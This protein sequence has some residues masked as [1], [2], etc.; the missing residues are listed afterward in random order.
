MGG[1]EA[2]AGAA[3][4]GGWRRE[5]GAGAL[6]AVACL[7]LSLVSWVRLLRPGFTHLLP[8][9]G[10][11]DDG[12]GVW[13]LEW[14]PFALGRGLDPFVSSYQLAPSGINL[15]SNTSFVLPALVL[16]PVTLTLGPI[17]AFDVGVIVAPVLSALSLWFVL[18][19]YGRSHLSAAT[20]GVL[21]GFAPGVLRETNLGHF[22]LTWLF[23]P[24]FV[25]FLLDRV[26]TGRR[27]VRDGAALGGVVVLQFFTSTEVLLMTAVVAGLVGLV[28]L[29]SAP[30]AAWRRARAA[31]AGLG[32]AFAVSGVL[33]AYPLDVDLAGARHVLPRMH[34]GPS[35]ANALS[36]PVWPSAENPYGWPVPLLRQVDAG[37]VGPV[38]IV[39]AVAAV[40]LPSTRSRRAVLAAVLALVAFLLSLGARLRLGPGGAT[41]VPMPDALLARVP[42]LHAVLP[43]RYSILMDFGLA[44]L[45]ALAMDRILAALRP[46]LACRRL[47]GRAVG[48]SLVVVVLAVPLVRVVAGTQTFAVAPV[49][50]PEVF[51]ARLARALLSGGG[52]VLEYPPAGL[53]D[54]L[55]LCWQAEAGMPYRLVDGY[56]WVPGPA[57]GDPP[58]TGIASLPVDAL[59]LAASTGHLGSPLP[60]AQAASLRAAL[61]S[62][63]VGSVVVLEGAPGAEAVAE[64]LAAALGR[65]PVEVGR[66]WL[67]RDV[68]ADLGR[69][70]GAA[71]SSG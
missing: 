53:Y 54:G 46:H 23:G 63:G 5:A 49:R 33:L 4:A 22:N 28:A 68:P 65:R 45:V 15:L 17:T 9:T 64:D 58:M 20:A 29:A 32:T 62:L 8:A 1:E 2:P 27:P 59:F 18:R 38:V 7:A 26:C 66:A 24:P 71:A 55:P 30:R 70:T 25:F 51:R 31:V 52:P 56:A 37:F 14:L 34:L 67:W 3:P 47:P 21:Y 50:T 57:P 44:F 36:S 11:G 48:A 10:F 60:A 39:L 12:Q 35:L 40:V 16:S 41:R 61:A 42:L 43:Y 13:F 6:L 69:M 19:R